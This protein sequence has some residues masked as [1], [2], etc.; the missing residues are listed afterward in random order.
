MVFMAWITI[1][2]WK[3]LPT[4]WNI[5]K[6]ITFCRF[7]F[8]VFLLLS[9]YSLCPRALILTIE[10]HRMLP[11]NPN[12]HRSTI[13]TRYQLKILLVI[14]KANLPSRLVCFARSSQVLP[15][16]RLLPIRLR[17][18]ARKVLRAM[19][20]QFSQFQ[21]PWLVRLCWSLSLS[22]DFHRSRCR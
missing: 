5:A 11:F 19:P 7:L 22:W 1:S 14:V 8:L 20:V 17:R 6:K 21:S 16:S 13:S 2:S 9:S 3:C 10:W 4:T 18:F 15:Q 12:A